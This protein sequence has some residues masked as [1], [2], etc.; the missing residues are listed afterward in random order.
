MIKE[1]MIYLH[2]KLLGNCKKKIEKKAGVI[3]WHEKTAIAKTHLL[4]KKK[5]KMQS[6]VY[7]MSP[8]V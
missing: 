2:N 4:S 1:A 5:K 3:Q 6:S 7:S 8:S